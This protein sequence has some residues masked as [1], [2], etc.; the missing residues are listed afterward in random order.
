MTERTNAHFNKIFNGLKLLVLTLDENQKISYANPFFLHLINSSFASIQGKNW[1]DVFVHEQNTAIKDILEKTSHEKHSAQ[2]IDELKT[3]DGNILLVKW[4]ITAL[5]NENSIYQGIL[6][7]GEDITQHMNNEASLQRQLSELAILH[8]ITLSATTSQTMDD[9]VADATRLL[10]SVFSLNNYGIYLANGTNSLIMHDSYQGLTDKKNRDK[11]IPST[12]GILG[13]VFQS[14]ELYYS[15]DVQKDKKY[16]SFDPRTKSELAVPI[17]LH[18][19][20]I[21]VINAESEEINA[22]TEEDKRLL[23]TFADTLSIAIEKINLFESTQQQAKEI[24]LLYETAIAT[25]SVLDSEKLFSTIYEKVKKILPL[26][27]FVIVKTVKPNN[28]YVVVSAIENNKR[29]I[30]WEGIPFQIEPDSPFG[31]VIQKQKP[32]LI[33][34]LTA[35]KVFSTP[36]HE[37]QPARSWL[38]IPLIVHEKAIGVMAVQSYKPGIFSKN[39]LHLVESLGSQIAITMENTRLLEQTQRQLERLSALHDIDLVINS[40]LDLRVTLNILLDQVVEKLNVDAAAVLLLNQQTQLLNFAAGRGFRTRTI[41]SYK[42]RLGEGISGQATMERHLVQALDLFESD[43]GM[44]YLPLLQEE[45]FLS[46]YSVPLIAKG[47][48]K[49]VLDIFNRKLITPDQDWIFFLETL[50]GQAAIAIDNTT[51]LENL[52]RSNIELSLAYDTTLEGWTRALDLRDQETEGHTQRVV[53]MTVRLAQLMGIADKDLIHIRRGALLHDI[54][55]MGIPD[56][57]LLK[58]GPLT[59][60]EWLIMRKHPVFAYNLLSPIAHL[61]QALDIPYCHHEWWN[62][63]GYPRQLKGEEIPL[64]ARIFSV[65]DVWDALT[66]DRPYRKAW[67]AKKTLDY[68]EEQKDIQFDPQVVELFLKLIK[69]ELFKKL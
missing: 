36:I 29:L 8:G 6:C 62:G 39:D 55:K 58:P 50:A 28:E 41:E 42:L 30:E 1:S 13:Y 51:L 35:E 57:I 68:I 67:N 17:R 38:G 7:I 46:F 21:G 31:W 10:T 33:Q 43:E 65:V 26:D 22:F 56:S 16:Y 23:T 52:Q 44:A 60:E 3:Q 66:S 54:G 47:Q 15:E 61:R 20:T 40:S 69:N 11:I 53:E 32:L 27:T 4:N 63:S 5:E 24:S 25:S 45:G 14:G 34:D 2:Y 49:G 59:E 19:A 9:L 48:V 18:Q 64:S 12:E 37:E